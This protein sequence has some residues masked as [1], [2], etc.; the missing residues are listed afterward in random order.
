[1][2]QDKSGYEAWQFKEQEADNTTVLFTD[3][4][5]TDYYRRERPKLFFSDD[6]TP[7]FLV[8]DMQEFNHR[9]TSYTLI[10]PM[11]TQ[12]KEYEKSLGF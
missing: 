12:Y 2:G 3:G 11:G 6:M 4:G 10:Q 7:L 1:M 9:G 5:R 8:N